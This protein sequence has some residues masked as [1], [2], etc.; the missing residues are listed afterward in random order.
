MSIWVK[1]SF[2]SCNLLAI[3][4][5]STHDRCPQFRVKGL[6]SKPVAMLPS[7]EGSVPGP[8]LGS[9]SH[10]LK[11]IEDAWRVHAVHKEGH[12]AGNSWSLKGP[13]TP[14]LNSEAWTGRML[15]ILPCVRAARMFNAQN[16]LE[17]L[18]RLQD[19]K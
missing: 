9:R 6:G 13:M 14:Y 11:I 15:S 19:L 7:P 2:S 8:Y 4:G 17:R 12:H 18:V 3:N 10:E 16:K 1:F 5:K